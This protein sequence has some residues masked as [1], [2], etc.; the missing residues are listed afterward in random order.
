MSMHIIRYKLINMYRRLKINYQLYGINLVTL[1]Y[2]ELTTYYVQ[3]TMSELSTTI[4]TFTQAIGEG[5]KFCKLL[6][7]DGRWFSKEIPMD[8]VGKS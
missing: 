1:L 3:N 7:K 5:T 2:R 6:H 8:G 4:W